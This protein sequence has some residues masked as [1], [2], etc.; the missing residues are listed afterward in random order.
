MAFVGFRFQGLG[1]DGAEITPCGW[2]TVSRPVRMTGG[3]ARAVAHRTSATARGVRVRLM[4][5]FGQGGLVFA[6]VELLGLAVQRIREEL[7]V[8]RRAQ[9]V[10]QLLVRR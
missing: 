2:S 6:E 10:L 9:V 4:V 3:W 1:R 7:R 8:A 5:G